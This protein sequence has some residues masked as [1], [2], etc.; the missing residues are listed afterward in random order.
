MIWR[1]A[2]DTEAFHHLGVSLHVVALIKVESA[3]QLLELDHVRQVNLGESHDGE[4]PALGGVS[5]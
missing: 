5:A 4:C 1:L 3:R 2:L